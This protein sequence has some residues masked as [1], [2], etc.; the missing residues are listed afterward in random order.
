MQSN[1]SSK[2]SVSLRRLAVHLKSVCCKRREGWKASGK[3][4]DYYGNASASSSPMSTPERGD[5]AELEFVTVKDRNQACSWVHQTGTAMKAGP[6]TLALAFGILDR[7]LSVLKVRKRLL[8][9]L[10][11]ASLSLAIKFSEDD[12]RNSFARYLCDASGLTFSMRDLTRM[13][14]LVCSKLDWNIQ[15]STPVEFLYSFFDILAN[16]RDFPTAHQRKA[17]STFLVAQLQDFE[18]AKLPNMEI[19][20][21]CIFIVFGGRGVSRLRL[22]LTLHG[23]N[24]DFA[25]A[26]E[27]SRLLKPNARISLRLVSKYLQFGE[28]DKKETELLFSVK[29]L[30]SFGY[31]EPIPFGQ[32][33]F[34][35]VVRC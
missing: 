21:G 33:T 10:A 8:R 26:Q 5:A 35:E 14:L 11:A 28:E 30:L 32:K 18:L 29:K 17:V 13:E 7:V 9:V 6:D 3:F 24:V 31:L 20:L 27:A 22:L 2:S 23:I 4:L 25:L 12:P 16:G 34:A 19:A 1:R 15:E